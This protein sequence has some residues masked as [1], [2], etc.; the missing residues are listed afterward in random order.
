M[1]EALERAGDALISALATFVEDERPT[2]HPSS[3]DGR[4]IVGVT[5]LE[6][7][8]L[9]LHD[10]MLSAGLSNV[11][12]AHRLGL[13]EKAVRRLRDPLRS[14]DIGVLET[15]LRSLGKRV[16]VTVRDAA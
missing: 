15:A 7:A 11:E 16:D 14:S 1:A 6:A 13:D 12:L 2:P 3:P 9:A 10:S 4:P 5:A 8:K